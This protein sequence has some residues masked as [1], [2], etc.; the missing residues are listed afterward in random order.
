[1][2]A[3]YYNAM[4]SVVIVNIWGD[5]RRHDHIF[6]GLTAIPRDYYEASCWMAPIISAISP[7]HIAIG[8]AEYFLPNVDLCHQCF[9][10]L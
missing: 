2:L 5:R 4:M 6:G 8:Y 9:S 7:G 1:M 10:S 3:V